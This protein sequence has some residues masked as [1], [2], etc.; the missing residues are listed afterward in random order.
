MCVCVATCVPRNQQISKANFQAHL[1]ILT[2]AVYH[3]DAILT[4]CIPAKQATAFYLIM[5]RRLF[6]KSASKSNISESLI[7]LEK[8]KM[9]NNK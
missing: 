9:Y 8:R 3:N 2:F 6:L 1:N 4:C 7:P 5:I